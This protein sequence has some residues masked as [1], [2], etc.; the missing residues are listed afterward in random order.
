M[1]IASALILHAQTGPELFG[2]PFLGVVGVVAAAVLG[3]GLVVG[4]LRSG[5]L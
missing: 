1:V 5:R 3:L 4:I 2:Y